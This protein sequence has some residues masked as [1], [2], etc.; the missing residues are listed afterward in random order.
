MLENFFFL[1]KMGFIKKGGCFYFE[2]SYFFYKGV[3][4]VILFDFEKVS[5]KRLFVGIYIFC[6]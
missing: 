5:C 3:G 6:C 2:I 4:G 1:L